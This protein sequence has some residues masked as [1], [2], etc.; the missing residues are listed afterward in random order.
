M[1]REERKALT[2]GKRGQPVVQVPSWKP[3]GGRLQGGFYWMLS[4]A[5]PPSAC[6]PGEGGGGG[7]A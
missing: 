4:K 3:L 1:A 2:W 7:R 6:S 5:P